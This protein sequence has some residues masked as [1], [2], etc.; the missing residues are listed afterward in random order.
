MVGEGVGPVRETTTP[1]VPRWALSQGYSCLGL[2]LGRG[3]TVTTGANTIWGAN[4][5]QPV[6]SAYTMGV[7]HYYMLKFSLTGE[8]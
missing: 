8:D 1:E 6:S 2:H 4:I 7:V 5:F 3:E